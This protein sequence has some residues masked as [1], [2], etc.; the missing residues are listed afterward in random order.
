MAMGIQWSVE[1]VTKIE[2][3]PRLEDHLIDDLFYQED[4]IEEMRHTAFMVK[5]GLEEDP[6]DCPD[7]APVPW[8]GMLLKKKQEHDD[9]DGVEDEIVDLNLNDEDFNN[10]INTNSSSSSSSSISLQRQHRELP[11]RSRSPIE[12]TSSTP[13]GRRRICH[14]LLAVPRT[15][16]PRRCKS[17]VE[18]RYQNKLQ[19]QLQLPFT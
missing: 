12:L 11:N 2:I 15:H 14:T 10:S 8:G 17:K 13:E 9:D 18:M 4:E 7:A 5:C 19:L 16:V 1:L 3:V 6:P